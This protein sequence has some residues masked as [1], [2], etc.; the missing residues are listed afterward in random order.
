MSHIKI[1]AARDGEDK[2]ANGVSIDL[3]LHNTILI[4]LLADH[5][6]NRI[7][8]G[9]ANNNMTWKCGGVKVSAVVSR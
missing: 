1:I 7:D 9:P 4:A 2:M 3:I 6:K 5:S 8:R